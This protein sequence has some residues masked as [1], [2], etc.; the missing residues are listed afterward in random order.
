[1]NNKFIPIISVFM[2][3]SLVVFVSLQ[4]Y[5]L[6]EYY[7]AL[8]QDFSNKVY[9]ALEN[10]S[11]KIEELEIQKYNE[12][13]KNFDKTLANNAKSPTLFQIQQT[14]DSANKTTLTFNKTIIE[15]QNIPISKKGDSITKIKL[16][17]DEGLYSIKKNE[18]TPQIISC[19][20]ECKTSAVDNLP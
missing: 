19:G 18:S 6:K 14:Q 12:K 11:K 4:F 1:M 5:W 2:T 8:E 15:K 20:S 17:K 3:I 13:F 7:T 10:S 16:Y 9:T